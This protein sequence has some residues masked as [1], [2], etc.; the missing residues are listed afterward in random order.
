MPRKWK[1]EKEKREIF[2]EDK[3]LVRGSKGKR[4][5]K[6]GNIWRRQIFCKWKQ[7]KA[8]N[9]KGENLEKNNIW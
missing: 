4:A 9:E 6:W 2:G 7:R 8:K 3:Y 5:R 1:T